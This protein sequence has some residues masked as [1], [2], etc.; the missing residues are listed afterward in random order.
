MHKAFH[1]HVHATQN[2][3]GM[4]FVLAFD[5]FNL[6]ITNKPLSM[7][8]NIQAGNIISAELAP[9]PLLTPQEVLGDVLITIMFCFMYYKARAGSNIPRYFILCLSSALADHSH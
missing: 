6:R 9:L 7:S 3:Q 5:P 8:V 4:P 1:E 2:S